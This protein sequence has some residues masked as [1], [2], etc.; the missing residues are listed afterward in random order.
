MMEMMMRVMVQ[1]KKRKKMKKENIMEKM[2]TF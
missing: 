2:T 1:T